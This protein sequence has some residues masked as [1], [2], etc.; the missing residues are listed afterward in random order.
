MYS[1]D[2][3]RSLLARALELGYAFAGFVDDTQ[4]GGRRIYLRHDVDYS[5]R[6]AVELAEINQSLGVRGTFCM[7]LRSQIYNLLSHYGLEAVRRLLALGQRAA[8][9]YAAPPVL[10]AS[11]EELAALIRADFEV[12]RRELPEI[13]PAFAW[14]NPTPE[15][16]ARGLH[17][18][19]PGLV[20][21]YS[22]AYVKTIP[23]YSDSNM[24]H[25]V[26]DFEAILSRDGHAALHL[27]LH[28]LNWVAGGRTMLEV[29]GRTWTYIVREREQEVGLNRA[30]AEAFPHGMPETVLQ[31]FAEQWGRACGVTLEGQQAM[32]GRESGG[33]QPVMKSKRV[34]LTALTADDLPVLFR[35]IN[36]REL[37]ERNAPYKPVTE[38]QHRAWFDAVQRRP[39]VRI[40]AIRLRESGKLI[41]SCQLHSIHGVHR[42]A[43]LQIRLGEAAERDHGYGPEALRLLLD[44]AFRG[45]NL[46]RVSLHVFST[47]AV[48]IRLYEKIGFVQEGVLRKAAH[49]DGRYLDVI[50]MG[51]LREEYVG[52]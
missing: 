44:V 40:F 21:L 35:W 51:I 39:D 50:V 5:L 14:H 48:A 41:G 38:Q 24:R 34:A 6:M 7:L 45:L 43:E 49:I 9:H 42:S 15:L 25:S 31:G 3:Y 52:R 8:F 27:L 33:S 29:L 4:A 32:S 46:H 23:Y 22:E 1:K 12:V 11:N 16:I 13:E 18:N 37:V 20:N 36:D 28:P 30:Y 47:N 10:P 17:L 26:A 2:S 19:V